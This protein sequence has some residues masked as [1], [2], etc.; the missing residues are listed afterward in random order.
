MESSALCRS[1]RELSNDY[2]IMIY[3]QNLASIQPRK[4][5]L[6]LGEIRSLRIVAGIIF[7]HEQVGALVADFLEGVDGDQLRDSLE[8]GALL[9]AERALPLLQGPR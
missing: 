3:L 6:K 2:Q 4:S 7:T 9:A 1:R 5:R 8:K